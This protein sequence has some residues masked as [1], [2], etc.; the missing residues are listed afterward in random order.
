MILISHRGN[1][2]GEQPSKENTPSY[3][4]EALKLGCDV[5]VDVWYKNDKWYLGHDKP[6]YEIEKSF[7]FIGGLW[8]HCKNINAL[9]I[10]CQSGMAEELNAFYHTDED[11][12]LTTSRYLWT[13]PRNQ[14]YSNSVC[15]IPE[16]GFI[17]D[18]KKCYGI[19]S[20]NIL[21]YKNLL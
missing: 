7:L 2:N 5:E 12:V 3:I 21:N 6:Q 15:V 19:C 16:L 14:L 1:I 18:L 4:L 11:V 13:Y 17:G 9:S 20:D 8:V 10:L